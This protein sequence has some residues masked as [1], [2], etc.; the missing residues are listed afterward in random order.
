[1]R[2][3]LKSRLRG[4]AACVSLRSSAKSRARTTMLAFPI[5]QSASARAGL[6]PS[7]NAMRAMH[8]PAT[9]PACAPTVYRFR[10]Q[11]RWTP[12]RPAKQSHRWWSKC[13]TNASLTCGVLFAPLNR[14]DVVGTAAVPLVVGLWTVTRV[15]IARSGPYRAI[16]E[17]SRARLATLGQ[18]LLFERGYF[19]PIQRN[20]QKISA[21]TSSMSSRRQLR[22]RQMLPASPAAGGWRFLISMRKVTQIVAATTTAT[23]LSLLA[24]MPLVIIWRMPAGQCIAPVSINP[25][26]LADQ[27]AAMPLVAGQCTIAASSPK[28]PEWIDDAS[29]QRWPAISAQHLRRSGTAVP[30]GERIERAP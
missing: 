10:R 26:N 27:A 1:M 13:P 25:L 8:S 23:A 2:A 28:S 19:I 6:S 21:L 17:V 24:A 5:F 3:E 9:S 15:S 7:F 4:G 16:G 20:L 29:A 22:T 11:R 18:S 30:P 14:L 12:S